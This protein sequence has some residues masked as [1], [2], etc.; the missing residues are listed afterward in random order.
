MND[1]K[2]IILLTYSNSIYKGPLSSAGMEVISL[3]L[4]LTD[5]DRISCE[6]H[7][8]DK[9]GT[10]IIDFT[11]DN[12]ASLREIIKMFSDNSVRIVALSD[13]ITD[14]I[15]RALLSAGISDALMTRDAKVVSDYISVIIKERPYPAGRIIVVDSGRPQIDILNSIIRRFNYTPVLSDSDTGLFEILGQS[16]IFLIF[17]NLASA[18]FDISRFVKK[19]FSNNEI[20]KIPVIAYKSSDDGLYIHELLSGLKRVTRVILSDEEVYGFLTGFLFRKELYPHIDT[21]ND[22]LE[23]NENIQ[24]SR[25][26]LSQIYHSM[27]PDIFSMENIFRDEKMRALSGTIDSLRES[28][29]R[30]EGMK[31]LVRD[32]KNTTFCGSGV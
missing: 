14:N 16:N 10:A 26:S 20:K 1:L 24:F 21:I 32:G 28:L 31:W 3:D 5:E 27:G 8:A 29:V 4:P 18:N 22:S 13:R 15:R 9:R 7:A 2:R 23:F 17:I 25:S 19:A 11:D 30:I 12:I 6:R